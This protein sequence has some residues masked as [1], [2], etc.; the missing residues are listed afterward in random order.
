MVFPIVAPP[1]P[2]IFIFFVGGFFGLL[3]SGSGARPHR[4]RGGGGG[5]GPAAAFRP[6]GRRGLGGKTQI[7]G[8][9]AARPTW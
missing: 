4:G 1:T 2:N 3:E 5:G 6:G 8:G 7:L 9:A